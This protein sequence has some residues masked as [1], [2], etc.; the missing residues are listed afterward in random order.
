MKKN[1]AKF[2]KR[3]EEKEEENKRTKLEKAQKRAAK[4]KAAATAQ[5]KD[6]AHTDQNVSV[7]QSLE[8]K[9][10]KDIDV[11]TDQL[12]IEKI[13]EF[14]NMQGYKNFTVTKM[15]SSLNDMHTIALT[16]DIGLPV[17]L[18]IKLHVVN[19]ILGSR[20]I[21]GIDVISEENFAAVIEH[22]Q[23]AF[24]LLADLKYSLRI[25]L[26]V[27][28]EET[29]LIVIFFQIIISNFNISILH[30]LLTKIFCYETK[31]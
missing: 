26:G 15:L 21:L 11:I 9:H 22:L 1:T 5:S 27:S 13:I 31:I 17:L 25:D 16:H 8:E 14:E 28:P 30:C 12:V 7:V 20:L 6:A 24:K 2:Y 18:Y 10:F 4:D 19:L 23:A 3:E 29:N